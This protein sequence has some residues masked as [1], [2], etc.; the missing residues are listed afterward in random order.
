MAIHER[1]YWATDVLDLHPADEILEIGCGAGI[2]ASLI[3]EKLTTGKL[4]A[5]DKS[6]AMISN[7]V[8]RNQANIEKGKAAFLVNDF[9]FTRFKDG[10]FHKIAAFNVNVFW[11]SPA[12][13][14][15]LVHRYLKPNGRLYLFFQ[16]PFETREEDAKPVMQQLDENSFDAEQVIFRKMKPTSALCLI[17]RPSHC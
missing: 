12:K 3:T 10:S 4:V 13:E 8:K 7:A 1:F 14:L 2:F 16:K 5:V 9:A 15:T 17:A 11:K 6:E